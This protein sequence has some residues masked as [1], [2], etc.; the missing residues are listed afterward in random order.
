MHV[1]PSIDGLNDVD[2]WAL[3]TGWYRVRRDAATPLDMLD[4][5]DFRSACKIYRTRDTFRV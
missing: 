3:L 4:M 2:R 5:L 1:G